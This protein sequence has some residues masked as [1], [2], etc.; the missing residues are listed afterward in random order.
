MKIT[1][2]ISFIQDRLILAAHPWLS[3]EEAKK[4]E[5]WYWCAVN[6]SFWWFDIIFSVTEW[7]EWDP[8]KWC[9]ILTPHEW[10]FSYQITHPSAF[11][12]IFWLPPCLARV[13]NGL[14]SDWFLY[15]YFNWRIYIRYEDN[16]DWAWNLLDKWYDSQVCERIII[17]PDWSP[18]TLFDQSP[19]T[20]SAIAKEM[21]FI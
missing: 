3:L 1:P 20:I 10:D 8:T 18:A 2:E 15:L 4:A 5:L 14:S 16:I 21:W 6:T 9:F 7:Y 17:N 13:L 19:E 11:N 12:D